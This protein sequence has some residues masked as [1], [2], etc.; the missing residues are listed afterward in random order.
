MT[1]EEWQERDGAYRKA[2]AD[3]ERLREQIRQDRVENG[4]L[5]RVK[6][7]IRLIARRAYI[8]S[9]LGKLGDAPRL[10]DGFGPEFRAAQEKQGLA[11]HAI[12]KARAAIDEIKASL[13]LINPAD[14]LLEAAADIE[15]LQERL[16]AVEKAGRDRVNI[17]GLQQENEHQARR[18]LRELGRPAD[19]VAAESLRLR[20]DLPAV[21]RGLGQ[22][23]AELRG[24]ADEAQRTIGAR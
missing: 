9:E 4:R 1:I 19:L 6:S 22:K 24:Q 3:A 7:A 14:T 2:L 17:E 21:I 13:A 11:E 23:F 12:A 15:S 16:G 5:M 10:R 20:A 8:S 18:L